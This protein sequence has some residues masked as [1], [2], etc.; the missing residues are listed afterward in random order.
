MPG[1]AEEPALESEKVQEE[2]DATN[3]QLVEDKHY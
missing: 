3:V 1:V 2:V